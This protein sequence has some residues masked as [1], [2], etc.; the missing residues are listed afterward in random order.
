M[1]KESLGENRSAGNVFLLG[2]ITLGIYTLVW[3]YRI[4]K[5]MKLHT[6]WEDDPGK[7]ILA[8][9]IPIANLVSFYRTAKRVRRM[10][11]LC[12]DSGELLNPG[13]TFACLFIP[14]IG[15]II[16]ISNVQGALN[17]HWNVHR[18]EE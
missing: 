6:D 12:G 2:I 16:Y 9:F 5:E 7:A 11:E 14:L 13:S 3:F 17:R 10:Q 4:N 1:P 18:A 8:L 15:G